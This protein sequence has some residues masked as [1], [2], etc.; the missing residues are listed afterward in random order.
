MITGDY[1]LTVE[2]IAKKIGIVK[3]E[4][5]R[6]ITGSELYKL[7]DD[8]LKHALEDEVI[9]ARVAPEQKYRV[10]ATLQELGHIVAV[11]GDGV[12]DAPALKKSR[13]RGCYGNHRN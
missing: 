2:S 12:N 6:V 4:H 9:F 10:V 7:S 8:E 3:T 11:T 1:G 5:P 13:Y